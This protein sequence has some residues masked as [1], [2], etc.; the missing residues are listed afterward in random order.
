MSERTN[1]S[2]LCLLCILITTVN[3][4]LKCF[5]HSINIGNIFTYKTSDN[6]TFTILLLK[7]LAKFRALG[8]LC[9]LYDIGPFLDVLNPSEV[10]FHLNPC[11]M[12]TTPVK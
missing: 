11:K 4:S 10:I 12:K 8:Y 1:L 6:F 3:T 9:L 2:N 7:V 5:F